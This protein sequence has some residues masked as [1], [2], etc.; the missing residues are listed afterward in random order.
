[1]MA[2]TRKKK[3]AYKRYLQTRDGTDYL[4]YTRVRNQAKTCC[5]TA[6][7][8]FE[9]K[10]ARNAKQNLKTFFMYARSKLKTKEGM[11]DLSAVES[12]ASSDTRQNVLNKF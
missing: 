1:M 10:I 2:K 3:Q 8:N 6:E 12:K 9:K 11:A 4:Y 5:R 7:R